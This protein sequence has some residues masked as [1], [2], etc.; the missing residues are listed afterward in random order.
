MNLYKKILEKSKEVDSKFDKIKVMDLKSLKIVFNVPDSH[1]RAK[2]VSRYTFSPMRI[3]ELSKKF[4]LDRALFVV[5]SYVSKQD[6]VKKFLKKAETESLIIE[7]VEGE[8]KTK[9]F[10]DNLIT[11]RNLDKIDKETICAVG[12]GLIINISAY[13]AEKTGLKLFL[14]PTSVLSMADSAGGKVRVN[15]VQNG[16]A[17]KHFYK[18]FYEPNGMFLDERFLGS[19]PERQIKIGLSEIVKHGLFQ[20]PKLYDFLCDSGKELFKDK[21][22]LKKAILWSAS[23]KKVCLDVD[24]EEREEGSKIILRGGHDFSDKLEEDMK[25][26]IPHGIAVSIG[27][28]EQLKE[29]KNYE[30][31][32]KAKKI[33]TLLEIPYTLEQF[34][35]F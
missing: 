29:E 28:I 26:K 5:D 21:S 22:K 33:F 34:K 18:S 2:E 30:L 3:E 14:F 17:H 6:F 9:H 12:G 20:S 7:S 19:L 32:E 1:P 13:L 27:I 4:P 8:S 11:E 10:L 23:L 16:R 15:L 31:L 24:V 35:N 25:L